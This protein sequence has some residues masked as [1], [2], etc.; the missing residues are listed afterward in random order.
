VRFGQRRLH[1][2]IARLWGRRYLDRRTRRTRSSAHAATRAKW[3][4]VWW[5]ATAKRIRRSV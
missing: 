1:D 5:D 3:R 2:R 4:A